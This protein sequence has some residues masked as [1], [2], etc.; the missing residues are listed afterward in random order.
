MTDEQIRKQDEELKAAHKD[1]QRDIELFLILGIPVLLAA[2]GIGRWRYR[3]AARAH[4][5]LA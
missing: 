5:S 2:Y 3:L 4:V 1:Q